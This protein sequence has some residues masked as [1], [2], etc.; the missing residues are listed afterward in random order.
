MSR[1]RREDSSARNKPN[2]FRF[3]NFSLSLFPSNFHLLIWYSP[4]ITNSGRWARQ[5]QGI[6]DYVN[7]F[8][9]FSSNSTIKEKIRR[10]SRLSDLAVGGRRKVGNASTNIKKAIFKF[11]P[12]SSPLDSFPFHSLTR[13][14]WCASGCFIHAIYAVGYLLLYFWVSYV[15]KIGRI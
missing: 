5:P 11:L 2:A 3:C 1:K 6:I 13:W 15:E 8:M 10:L 9:S 12:R 7:R 14:C 4:T